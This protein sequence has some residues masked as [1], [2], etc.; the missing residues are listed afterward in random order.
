MVKIQCELATDSMRRVVILVKLVN[1]QFTNSTK[2]RYR[3]AVCSGLHLGFFGIEEAQL[4]PRDPRDAVAQ[5]MLNIPCCIT[6]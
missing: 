3:H 2:M 1:S 4:S 6:W 5:S